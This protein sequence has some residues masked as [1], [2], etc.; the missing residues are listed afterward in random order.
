VGTRHWVSIIIVFNG[1][2]G[3]LDF[4]MWASVVKPDG[5]VCNVTKSGEG[6]NSQWLGSRVI[7]AQKAYTAI[8]FS[9]PDL[10]LST[11]NLW[12]PVQPGGS[13]FGLQF[14]NPVDT[15]NAYGGSSSKYGSRQDPMRGKKVG[16]V[17][18]FG[19]GLPLYNSQGR[20][21]GAIGV[22]GD[23]SCADHNIAWRVRKALDMDHVPGGVGALGDDNIVYD[24]DVEGNSAGGFGH[25]ECGF[26]SRP[27]S[28]GFEK[29]GTE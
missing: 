16:G 3:G 11:A 24:L 29:A 7:S 13:L 18:V 27:I 1:A 15:K 26:S 14:S 19:G 4:H 17:N 10:A 20:L 9:K 6:I 28:E 21:I 8:A 12:S 23:T 22:S 25:P 5:T 2:N